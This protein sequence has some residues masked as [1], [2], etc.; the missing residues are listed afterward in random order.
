MPDTQLAVQ[1][2]TLRDF[3]K[4]E[5]DFAETCRKLKAQ[6]WG[7]VQ[8]SAVDVS[9]L[10]TIKRIL[11]DHGLICCATH[12]SPGDLIWNDPAK[13]VDDLNTLD[14]NYTAIGGYFPKPEE[15]TAEN[16]KQW[17]AR[18]NEAAAKYGDTGKRIGYHNHSHEFAKLGGKADIDGQTAMELLAGRLR[19]EVW[20][21]IDTY[22]VAH[23]GG[24]PAAWLRRLAGRVPV[25]HLKDYAI[26]TNRQPYM[27]EI[28]VGNLNWPGILEAAKAV[29][30]EWYCVEQDTC[31]RDAF[32]SLQTSLE[33]CRKLGLR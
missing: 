29:G 28:G 16:W 10:K 2:Y 14:C 3:C 27:A 18:F 11:D 9:D 23:G 30:V 24:C 1:L 12:P 19:E 13:L 6:G 21:E 22:W 32:D 33:N 31:Y 17:I 20:F 26:D 7:A 15:F 25:I 8:V 4:T 5:S